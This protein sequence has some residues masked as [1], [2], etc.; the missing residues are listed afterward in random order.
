V[1]T[2]HLNAFP[3]DSQTNQMATGS[4]VHAKGF[5]NVWVSRLSFPSFHA[6]QPVELIRKKVRYILV[7]ETTFGQDRVGGAKE[8]GRNCVVVEDAEL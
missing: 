7:P 1:S 3:F 2:K 5:K 4:K 8:D 6:A